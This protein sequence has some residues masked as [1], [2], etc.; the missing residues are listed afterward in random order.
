MR[1]KPQTGSLAW[2]IHRV[3]GLLLTLY[4]FLHLYVLSQL[5]DPVGYASVLKTLQ[6]PLVRLGEAGL[7]AVVIGHALNGFRVTLLEWG[8]QTVLQKRLFW[9]AFAVGFL[10]FIIGAVPILGG[11]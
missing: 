3:S 11:G 1:Y 10:L 2:A 8:V 9:G 5:K 7:L 4:I 6:L